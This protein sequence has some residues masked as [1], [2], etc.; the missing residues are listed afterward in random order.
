[1]HMQVAWSRIERAKSGRLPTLD[2]AGLRLDPAPE[3]LWELEHL[4]HLNLSGTGMR[5]LPVEIARLSRLRS[6]QLR[7]NSLRTLP[8]EI[9]ALSELRSL[10]LT[11]TGLVE[12]PAELRNLTQLG[13]LILPDNPLLEIPP[14]VVGSK[15]PKRILDYYFRSL[16]E[17]SRPLLEAKVLVVG[18]GGVGKTSLV[19]RLVDGTFDPKEGKTEGIDIHRWQV[20]GRV[21][22]EPIRV[23]I[24]DF[25][26]Q[27]IMHATHQF[28][29]TKRSLYLLVLDA[30]KGEGEGNLHYWLG[31]I[32]SFGA[33]SPVLVVT[34]QVEPPNHLDLNETR[35]KKNFA[36]SIRGFYQTSCLT[37][38]GIAELS[39]GI[40]SELR[41]LEHVYDPLPESFFEVKSA[42]EARTHEED[43]LEIG[44]YE[45]IC[46]AHGLEDDNDQ[47]HLLR[48]LHDLGSV[49]HFSD[50][51][52]PFQLEETKIL[53]P[54]WVTRGVYK[55]LNNNGLMQ[56]EGVLRLGQLGR[57]LRPREGYPARHRRF[58]VG[59][60]RKF[61]LCF[62][63]PGDDGRLL[64]PEL[65]R[66][67]E[68]DLGWDESEA[69]R[70][71]Y[72]YAVLP[73]GLL[74]RFITRSHAHL[75][76]Q[77]TYWRSG[78]VLEI[79]GNKALVRADTQRA[80]V[81]LGVFG[82]LNGRRRA[83]TALRSQL[84]AIHRTM[85]GIKA[86]A[87]VPL[88]RDPGVAESY[89][90]LLLLEGEGIRDYI[91]TGSRERYGVQELLDGI[92]SRQERQQETQRIIHG[93]YYELHGSQVGSVGRE[94]AAE[95]NTFSQRVD[96]AAYDVDIGQL[97]EEL[98]ALRTELQNLATATEHFQAL[99]AVS[100]A[101]EAAERR[102]ARATME[103]LRQATPWAL[104]AARRHGMTV[105]VEAIEAA[106][107]EG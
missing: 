2:L 3:K 64:V 54:E 29:L 82:P 44:A 41:G 57:I 80:R 70:F 101:L 98:A 81:Y 94:A 103:R 86:E 107:G 37:G 13:S 1:M 71:E 102:E 27:E 5:Q 99:V 100:G 46:E 77:P 62:S 83:M 20:P 17:V 56:A 22:D 96:H 93:D 34:N 84:Q 8:A 47:Q 15:S 95:A 6:L 28:F 90:H 25:G 23:N 9:G 66:K 91:P 73:E 10:D 12:L 19:R 58:I 14:E 60:M 59:M 21:E 79:D 24:W 65:L 39:D 31:I 106:V 45:A 48:F 43:F 74:P 33:D 38:E 32:Q 18:Q 26:G 67:N 61:E 78:V 51:D 35:L 97:A 42:L 36:P 92:E 30:R 40:E 16:R 104:E 69:L 49:L 4:E 89:D 55:I 85:P 76:E 52:S 7:F 72:H 63:F 68:P 105:A 53:N 88:P 75:G 11:A 50:P 87:K